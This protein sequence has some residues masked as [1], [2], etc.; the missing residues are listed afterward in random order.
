MRRFETHALNQIR[1]RGDPVLDCTVLVAC[2]GGGDSVALLACLAALRANLKIELAVAH[3]DHGLRPESAEEADYVQKLC[4][5]FG[6]A[7]AICSLD[8]GGHASKNNIGLETAAREMRWSWLKEQALAFGASWVAT[9]HTIEDHTETVLLRL[10]RGS[11]LGCLSGL[12]AAQAPR[13]SPLIECRREELRAYLRGLGLEWC[14]DTTNSL[15]FTARNRWRSLLVGFRDEAPRIDRHLWE[16]HRQA[17]DL[18]ALRN[19]MV[20]SWRG[21]RWEIV[22]GNHIW[23]ALT[24]RVQDLAWV[25]EAA[26]RELGVDREPGHIFDLAAWASKVLARPIKRAWKW[27]HWALL[28]KPGGASLQFDFQKPVNRG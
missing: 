23:L 3:V 4:G 8:V 9:G 17:A 28:P 18:L 5:S 27:G 21:H 20:E 12:P 16:T 6:L 25:L 11:G 10:A 7:H 19:E 26:F 22:A 2:S 1:R 14:E 24:W 13:W 15:G